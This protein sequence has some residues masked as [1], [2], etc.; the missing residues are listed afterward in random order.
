[1]KKN[2]RDAT[3][4]PCQHYYPSLG[5]A[6]KALLK[7]C[8]NVTNFWGLYIK[9]LQCDYR[10]PPDSKVIQ[11]AVEGQLRAQLL[12]PGF[13][14]NE[15]Q[16]LKSMGALAEL[17]QNY[18]NSGDI[19]KLRRALTLVRSMYYQSEENF[20]GSPAFENLEMVRTRLECMNLFSEEDSD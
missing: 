1:M 7:P 15:T 12:E 10:G 9:Y 4:T 8:V 2:E 5:H 6:Y 13:A 3:D 14:N 19:H 20:K 16:F 17:A 18:I 11:E